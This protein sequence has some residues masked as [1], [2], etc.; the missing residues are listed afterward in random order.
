MTNSDLCLIV[1]SIW[2]AQ[3]S[4]EDKPFQKRMIIAWL[5]LLALTFFHDH[6]SFLSSIFSWVVQ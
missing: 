5:V 6:G 2:T 4:S 1:L 3:A